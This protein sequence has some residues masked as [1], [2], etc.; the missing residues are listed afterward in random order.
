VGFPSEAAG[1]RFYFSTTVHFLRVTIEKQRIKQ[2]FQYY[3]PGTYYNKLLYLV[4]VSWAEFK[5]MLLLT[6]VEEC[7]S[8]LLS[9]SVG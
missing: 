6:S 2:D 4:C 3:K 8:V 5:T 1:Q 9:G 7:P